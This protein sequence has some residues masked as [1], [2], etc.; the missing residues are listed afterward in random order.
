VVIESAVVDGRPATGELPPGRGDVE[1]RFAAITL[2]EPHRARHR[3]LL[4]GF[5]RDWVD[6]GTRR[7]AHYTNI[8]PGHYRFRVRG[9]NADGV[10]NE[11]GAE[12]TF[13]IRPHF[14]RTAWFY[15]LVALAALSL[16]FALYRLRLRSLGRAYVAAFEERSRLARELHD[17]LLQG[18]AAIG[19]QLRGVRRRI[20]PAAPAAARAL[21]SVE[22]MVTLSLDETRRL[23]WNLRD[24]AAQAGDLG[25]ALARLGERLTQGRPVT[26]STRVEGAATRL[27]NGVQDQLFRIAQEAVANAVKHAAA[28]RIT[29]ELEYRG[30]EVRLAIADDGRGFDPAVG[31]PAG[32]FGLVGMRERAARIGALAIDSRPGG[33]TRVEINVRAREG[34]ASDA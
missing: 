30:E 23:V 10:W 5:D 4:E 12:V 18:M 32:H 13:S 3:Y 14:Y 22:D 26:C 28:H 6:A 34:V 24:D 7:V 20:E 27:P 9:A 16:I 11:A 25:V 19:M 29:I 1:L 15:A 31:A 17:T 21:E 33:G 8:P 2:V